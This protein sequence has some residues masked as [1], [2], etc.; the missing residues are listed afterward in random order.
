MTFL[1]FVFIL[2]LLIVVH[3][4]GHFLMA[5]KLGV[6][7]EEFAF[8]FG[9]KLCGWKKGDTDYRICAIPL[10][11]YVKMA[12]DERTNCKGAPDE[13]FSKSMG[14]RALIIL[15]GPVVNYLLAYLCF[16]VV[17][18]IGAVDLDASSKAL[19][20]KVGKVMAASAAQQAGFAANDVLI[21]I[22]GVKILNWAEMQDRVMASQGKTLDVEVSR[23]QAVVALKVT[24]RLEKT[25][26]IFGREHSVARIGIQPTG[27]D[28]PEKLVIKKYGFFE[29]FIKGAEEL[30]T[31]TVKTY[32]SLWEI[33]TGQRSA[34]D[35]VTGLVGIFFIVKFAAGVGF[36]FL[37]HIVGIISASLALFNVLPLIPLDGGHLA[38]IGLEKLRGRALSVKTEDIVMKF[39]FGLIIALAIFVFYVD[40]ERIGLIDKVR[41]FFR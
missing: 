24:P 32:V 27:L 11:G 37:L 23:G 33:V 8:G 5:R 14:Q 4:A 36:S 18:W 3:E 41:A 26:D 9:P 16:V 21:S 17:F 7:V 29:S 12:G 10:G 34:K 13:Y 25:K 31:I 1:I 20:A 2:G 19:P 39:G 28:K 38:L 35:G 6:R 30:S 22:D 15:M 40:F